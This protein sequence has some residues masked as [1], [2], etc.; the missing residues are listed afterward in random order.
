MNRNPSLA[1][2]Y[3]VVASSAVVVSYA[4]VAS[5]AVVTSYAV[6]ASSAV[7]ASYDYNV[8]MLHATTKNPSLASS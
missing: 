5:S 2:S 8:N 3:T 4:V 7:V 6:V 1:S